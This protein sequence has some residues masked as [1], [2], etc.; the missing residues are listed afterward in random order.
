MKV[1]VLGGNGFI[2]SHMVDHLIAAG[3]QVC[4][5]DRSPERFREPL[6]QVEYWMGSFDDTF[7][8]AEALHGV[9]AV[10]HLI[11]TTSTF[12]VT[13]TSVSAGI[14]SKTCS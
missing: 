8:V 4:V 2:G 11:S 14:S 9:D 6:D 7:Q 3:H 13:S 5:F 12:R 1:L 10:C